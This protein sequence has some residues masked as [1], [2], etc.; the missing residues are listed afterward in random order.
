MPC[1]LAFGLPSGPDIFI[2]A[3]ILGIPVGIVGLVFLFRR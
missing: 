1:Q 3:V 2:L